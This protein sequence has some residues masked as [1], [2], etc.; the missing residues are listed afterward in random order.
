MLAPRLGRV[1]HRIAEFGPQPAERRPDLTEPRLRLAL[2]R[3]ARQPEPAETQVDRAAV[4]DGQI[5][6]AGIGGHPLQR[7][8]QIGVLPG[9]REIFG[10]HRLPLGMRGAEFRG[11]RHA[12]QMPDRRPAAAEGEI[13][14]L[15]GQHDVVE[16]AGVRPGDAI[17]RGAVIVDQRGDRGH[18][19]LGPDRGEIG[20]VGVGQQR[21][22][23]HGPS[24][25]GGADVGRRVGGCDPEDTPRLDLNLSHVCRQR[26][27]H[28]A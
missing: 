28:H 14:A 23:H 19:M 21:I 6:K 12:V 10:Q 27:M 5:G 3:D 7:G 16:A 1:Q 4:G 11:V 22:G 2:Q 20:E 17:D 24:A 8:V 18:D 9:D 26:V 15:A 13:G 25:V